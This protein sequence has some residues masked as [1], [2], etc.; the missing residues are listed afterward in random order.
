MAPLFR[1]ELSPVGSIALV[2]FHT[3]DLLRHVCS[4][5]SKT[6][7][8]GPPFPLS[9]LVFALAHTRQAPRA[10][11]HPVVQ[12]AHLHGCWAGFICHIHDGYLLDLG[13]LGTFWEWEGILGASLGSFEA[14]PCKPSTPHY[15]GRGSADRKLGVAYL[16]ADL[17]A[18]VSAIHNKAVCVC[19]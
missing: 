16:K 14:C 1:G 6:A 3:S 5:Q 11:S 9:A 17:P 15:S 12:L 8:L 19:V 2:T 4:A 18:C 13:M 10:S 7:D